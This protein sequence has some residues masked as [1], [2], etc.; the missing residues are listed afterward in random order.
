MSQSTLE[1]NT[2]PEAGAGES[3][4]P[5]KST[6]PRRRH[7]STAQNTGAAR[8]VTQPAEPVVVE[9]P[10]AVE[11]P[12]APT[13][14]TPEPVS[15]PTAEVSATQAQQPEAPE[16]PKQKRTSGRTQRKS[17]DRRAGRGK[18]NIQLVIAP[19]A[20]ESAE[21]ATPEAAIA[22]EAIAPVESTAP[23]QVQEQMQAPSG[24][25]SLTS[26]EARLVPVTTEP[27]APATEAGHAAEAVS[28]PAPRRYRFDRRPAAPPAAPVRPERISGG[29]ASAA[30][31]P[32]TMPE[33]EP[34]ARAEAMVEPEMEFIAPA[35]REARAE[36]AIDDIV[37][38]LGLR[39]ATEPQPE[40]A[41]EEEARPAEITTPEPAV[42][43][44]EAEAPEAEAEAQAV[45]R[46][47]R[48][49]RRSSGGARP[50]GAAEAEEEAEEEEPRAAA[51]TVVPFAE[52][53]TERESRNGYEKPGPYEY[54]Y[55][56][57]PYSPYTRPPR[58][59]APQ[60]QP[61]WGIESAQ[62]TLRQPESP[63]A[64]P[65]P[66]FARGFGPQPRGIATPAR[67]V[68]TRPGRER[69]TDVPPMSSNQL[70]S[71]VTQAIQQQ[72]D[73]L[74]SEMRYQQQPPSMT[75]TFP[76]F[77]STERVGVF[78]D[79][80][81]L[82]Y[83]A[84]SLRVSLDFGRLLD[85][86]RGNRRLIR[87]QAYA[88][89]NPDPHAEQ[90]FLSVVKGLGYRIT[91]KNYKTFS[92]GAKKA[93]LDLD[94]CMDIVRLVDAGALDTVVLVSGDSDFLPLLEYCSDH[95]VRVEVAAFDDSA[96]MILR[97]SCDLFVNLSLVEEIR[98]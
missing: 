59:R 55:P 19:N 95:G 69:G 88:P 31:L 90:A 82:L 42:E 26:D 35:A 89:T 72:T 75:V 56:E 78:V 46:R 32:L 50:V 38:A 25:P 36:V 9:Q 91:T 37:A 2:P 96:A 71:M 34:E 66:S 97:Q 54:G 93:D 53:A 40:A 85:F 22:T 15:A 49:R 52:Q 27:I 98:A 16:Q 81:N 79:V 5:R 43:A 94:L 57:Q 67:E 58:E 47:R 51:P 30:E 77:P 21:E 76:P 20:A 92:S 60:P 1:P 4:A 8:T 6:P 45:S 39:E 62:Q 70:A 23:E 83:S 18:N 63:F 12:E 44:E 48:R 74:L 11:Q 61:Q 73:R 87:A 84:R 7:R 17:G 68:Y 65:E 13:S 41:P 3:T 14:A 29:Q 10:A 24:E 28:K 64:G 33:P 86:L 80:A